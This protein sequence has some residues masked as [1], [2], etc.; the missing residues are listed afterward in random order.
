MSAK[1]A[2]KVHYLCHPPHDS[3]GFVYA[4]ELPDRYYAPGFFCVEAENARGNVRDAFSFPARL[5]EQIISAELLQVARRTYSVNVEGVGT[6]YFKL[7][8]LDRRARY[9]GGRAEEFSGYPLYRVQPANDHYLERACQAH[10]F[11]FVGYGMEPRR[12]ADEG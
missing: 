7:V 9:I 6:F 10:D 8:S 1:P 5:G 11:Y 4:A 2:V 12:Q 3:V